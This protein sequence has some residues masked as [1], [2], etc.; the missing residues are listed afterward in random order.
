MEFTVEEIARMLGGEVRGEGSRRVS[1]FARIEEGSEGAISFLSNLRYEP[2]LYTTKSSAVIVDR[3]F[4]PRQDVT[5]TLILV[6]NP[7]AGFSRLLEAYSQAL[8]FS[9]TGTEEPAFLGKNA[10]LGRGVYRGAFSYIGENCRIGN[11]VKIYPQ[12]YLGDGVDVGDNTILYP[13]VKVYARCSIGSGCTLHA[14]AII[15]ADGF[16][17]APQADGSYQTI[18]QLGRVILEDN[19]SVG[20]G[21]TIDCATMPQD[22]TIIRKGVKLDNLVQVAHNVEIGPHTVVAAQVGISGSTKIGAFCRVGG[23]AGIGGHLH[24]A[25]RTTIAG[26]SGVSKSVEESGRTVSGFL[27]TDSR[28]YMKSQAIFRR[29]PDLEKQLRELEK[30]VKNLNLA[31]PDDGPMR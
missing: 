15:G 7:Y 26:Q 17:F 23:Q 25:D 9:K 29:L 4:Q 12:V 28:D 27:A 14:N 21:T 8:Q 20:A 19:V 18:P 5:T 2:F 30:I 10:T 22:A 13:G 24:I 16:G 3:G 6:E 31:S 11:N 1:R